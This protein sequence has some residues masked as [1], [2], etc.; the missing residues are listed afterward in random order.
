[1]RVLCSVSTILPSEYIY[2]CY[3][4]YN[5]CTF[6]NC[7]HACTHIHKHVCIHEHTRACTHACTQIHSTM[8]TRTQTHKITHNIYTQYAHHIHCHTHYN[9]LLLQLV[10]VSSERD[11]AFEEKEVT[12]LRSNRL[13]DDNKQLLQR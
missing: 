6:E 11:Q 3:L 5:M 1:M 4:C 13:R 2:T 7:E 12:T 9:H 10:S 8:H